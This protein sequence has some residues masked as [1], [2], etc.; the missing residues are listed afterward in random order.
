MD[1]HGP[2]A[3]A[4]ILLHLVAYFL[5]TESQN[6]RFDRI[7]YL[8]ALPG[9]WSYGSVVNLNQVLDHTPPQSIPGIVQ[10]IEP[11]RTHKVSVQ[12][13]EQDV[14][15]KTFAVSIKEG[16]EL[17][18]GQTITVNRHKGYFDLTWYDLDLAEK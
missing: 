11:G 17:R 8:L 3:L 18:A 15:S 9:F 10:S 6:I 5:S 4:L 14:S 12:V 1:N 16:H 2:I 13:L 7:V